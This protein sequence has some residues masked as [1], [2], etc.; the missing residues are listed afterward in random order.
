MMI[1]VW[2]HVV[3]GGREIGEALVAHPHID[4]LMFTGSTERARPSSGPPRTP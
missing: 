4:K 2:L 1:S 3:S